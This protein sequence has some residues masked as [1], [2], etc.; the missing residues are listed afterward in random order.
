MLCRKNTRTSGVSV[1]V[2]DLFP[3]L[4]YLEHAQKRSRKAQRSS[5]ASSRSTSGD[6]PCPTPETSHH[7]N[8]RNSQLLP[9]VPEVAVESS[10]EMLHDQKV[11]S[12]DSQTESHDNS[13]TAVG[14]EDQTSCAN[15]VVQIDKIDEEVQKLAMKCKDRCRLL[16][17][18]MGGSP[19]STVGTSSSGW[20]VPSEGE[21]VLSTNGKYPLESRLNSFDRRIRAPSTDM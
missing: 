11:G 2:P 5:A 4:K 14:G 19:H 3:V 10:S 18:D 16:S 15:R 7:G 17:C 8:Q 1:T 6:C 9:S 13:V 21:A 12:H 20:G